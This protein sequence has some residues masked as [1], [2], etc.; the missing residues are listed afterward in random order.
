MSMCRPPLTIPAKRPRYN[1]GK[2]IPPRR[3]RNPAIRVR[4]PKNRRWH[5]QY[6][7]EFQAAAEPRHHEVPRLVPPGEPVSKVHLPENTNPPPPGDRHT[8]RPPRPRRRHRTTAAGPSQYEPCL[9][10]RRPHSSPEILS[11]SHPPSRT[12][13]QSGARRPLRRNRPQIAPS[14]SGRLPEPNSQRLR[15]AQPPFR[16]IAATTVKTCPRPTSHSPA[17]S[18]SRASTVDILLPPPSSYPR[19]DNLP[20]RDHARDPLAL[21]PALHAAVSPGPRPF[22]T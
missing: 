19:K 2:R 15:D 8:D 6:C 16:A 7:V 11:R 18:A 3:G 14:W 21:Q 10:R 12:H 9:Q 13:P 20:T 17:G 1:R 4:L 5:R 22:S